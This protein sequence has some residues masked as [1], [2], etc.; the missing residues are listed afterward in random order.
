[1]QVVMVNSS[2]D[3]AACTA[4]LVETGGAA[5]CFP[6]LQHGCSAGR[7][8]ERKLNGCISFRCQFRPEKNHNLQLGSLRTRPT[9][10][11][12]ARELQ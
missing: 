10:M 3:A 8:L 9:G 4:A 2:L 6:A 1:M 5:P 12:Q 11:L 7:S